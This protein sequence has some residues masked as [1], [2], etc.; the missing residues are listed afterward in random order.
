M[1]YCTSTK[2]ILDGILNTHLSIHSGGN[3]V[4]VQIVIG[5]NYRKFRSEEISKKQ[6][7]AELHRDGLLS[8]IKDKKLTKYVFTFKAFCESYI[9]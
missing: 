7:L 5:I 1:R 6:M 3:R 4:Y 2:N 9:K 8:S